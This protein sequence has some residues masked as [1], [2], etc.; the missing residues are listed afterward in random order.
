MGEHQIDD[1]AI[2]VLAVPFD[3]LVHDRRESGPEAVGHVVAMIAGAVEQIADRILA[4]RAIGM[5]IAGKTGL[6]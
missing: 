6:R 3:P 4:H 5:A 1:L 2:M